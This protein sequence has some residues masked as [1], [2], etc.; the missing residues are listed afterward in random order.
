MK[1]TIQKIKE[2]SPIKDQLYFVSLA[3]GT[4]KKE[5]FILSQQHFYYAV[6]HFSRPMIAL[7]SRLQTYAQRW[8]LL[9]NIIEEHGNGDPNK[10]H[11]DS[12][13]HFLEGFGTAPLF[14]PHFCIET[15]NLSLDE[16]CGH[17]DWRL[18]T[19][20]LGMIED[21]FAEISAFT[22]QCIVKQK[23]L[24]EKE[25]HHYSVHKDLDIQ[26]AK[27]LY[28]LVED[29]WPNNSELIHQ[30][31]QLGNDLFLQLYEQLYLISISP[32]HTQ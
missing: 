10:T 24:N 14:S 22:A 20:C 30:G 2:S 1:D 23:W 6:L 15:F 25:I 8:V 4:L 28:Q 12:F 3:N 27:D 11:G 13:L 26:H 16:I 29:E 9:E 31:L 19:A 7:A 32:I 18:A 21:R 5:D 17:R